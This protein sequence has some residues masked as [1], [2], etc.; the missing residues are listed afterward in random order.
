MFFYVFGQFVL[1]FENVMFFLGENVLIC[2][3]FI[4]FKVKFFWGII[5]TSSVYIMVKIYCDTLVRLTHSV[6]LG[7]ENTKFSPTMM[8]IFCETLVKILHSMAFYDV[9]IPKFFFN[10]G[11]DV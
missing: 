11:E 1:F 8:K 10:H 4:F 5:F 9:K 3:I 2:P 6:I 7:H